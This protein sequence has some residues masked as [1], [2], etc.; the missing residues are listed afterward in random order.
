MA[1]D[2]SNR[3]VCQSV[4]PWSSIFNQYFNSLWSSGAIWRHRFQSILAQVMAFL[5]GWQSCPL[6][7]YLRV[8]SQEIT[9]PPITKIGLK[10][11]YLKFSFGYPSGKRINLTQYYHQTSRCLSGSNRLRNLYDW[12]PLKFIEE[13]R[14]ASM[15]AQGRSELY[16]IL[17]HVTNKQMKLNCVPPHFN[18]GDMLLFYCSISIEIWIWLL[19]FALL[20]LCYWWIHSILFPRGYG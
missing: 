5:A 14:W 2:Y 4:S 7:N 6:K 12:Q 15:I 18:N 8:I 10:S 1:H 20:F 11:T 16:L 9:Q 13:R 3:F 19:C 17:G